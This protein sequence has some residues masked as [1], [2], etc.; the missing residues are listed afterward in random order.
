MIESS[1][2]S[3]D[4][5]VGTDAQ[6]EKIDGLIFDALVKKDEHFEMTPWLAKSWEQQPDGLAWVF[7]L[8]DGVRFQDG[9]PLEAADV[10]YTIESLIDGSL[11][12]AKGGG[13]ASVKRV[14]VR[15]RLTVVVEMKHADQT[16][17]FNVS[18]GIFGV[19]PRGAGKDFAR[20]PIG[21][22]AFR[23]VSAA[24]D[25]EVVLE[26]TPGYW[27]EA[28]PAH[29]I[30]RLRLSVIPDAVTTALELKKG[31]ADVAV[32]VVT[33][34]MVHVLE[35]TPGLRDE[36]GPGSPVM[37]VNFN[38][39]HGVTADKR[40]RQAIA[41]AMDR[42]AIVQA[43]WRGRARLAETLLPLGHWAAA[44]PGELTTYPPRCCAGGSPA[45]SGRL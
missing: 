41:L 45:R 2:N 32:N 44:P 1:P 9:R 35:Q 20:T 28:E 43:L 11:T 10:A 21:S 7:R 3:L 6:S 17:L 31:S 5:R 34:D 27:A 38:C 42:E 40:V 19:V 16:L 23:F 33:L 12:T 8:R 24:A 39:A 29:G 22:G 25:K 37:Y 4:P 36:T 30:D 18:D 26:R 15:D 13:F 14:Y